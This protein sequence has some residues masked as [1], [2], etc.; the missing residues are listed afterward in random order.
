[1]PLRDRRRR[2]VGRRLDD[3]RTTTEEAAM[4]P[5]AKALFLLVGAV[6]AGAMLHSI[7]RAEAAVLGLSAV[8]LALLSAA[9]GALATRRLT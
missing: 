6:A 1:V 5:R 2:S 9:A 3:L 4:D 7:A 8:E